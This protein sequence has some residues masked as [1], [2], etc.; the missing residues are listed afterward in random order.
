MA[1]LIGHEAIEAAEKSET[2]VLCK[3][4]DPTEGAREGLTVAEARA[5]TKED[6]GLIW[7]DVPAVVE[8]AY[9]ARD[10]ADFTHEPPPAPSADDAWAELAKWHAP[11]CEWIATRARRRE[12]K[13]AS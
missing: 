4:A 6:P 2:I 11:D 12:A 5:V 13:V 9:C 10:V 7:A 1:K 8:C 3:Y